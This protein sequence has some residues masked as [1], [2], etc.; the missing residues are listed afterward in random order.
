LPTAVALQET[1]ETLAGAGTGKTVGSLVKEKHKGKLVD[2]WN[3]V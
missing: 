2:E 3:K 1:V